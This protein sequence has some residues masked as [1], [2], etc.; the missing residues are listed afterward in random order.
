MS[1]LLIFHS[2]TFLFLPSALK[3]LLTHSW[4]RDRTRGTTRGSSRTTIATATATLRYIP[5]LFLTRDT[6]SPCCSLTRAVCPYCLRRALLVPLFFDARYWFPSSLT[7]ATGSPCCSLTRAV[8]PC[9]LR[10][11]LLVPLFFLIYTIFCSL[12]DDLFV[13]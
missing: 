11:A 13:F 9:S 4:L 7:R 1:L 3:N 6:G 8:C 2:P 10:R 5:L 12:T